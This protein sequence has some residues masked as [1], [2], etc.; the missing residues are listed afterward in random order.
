M[1]TKTAAAPFHPIV[2]LE[3]A[4]AIASIAAHIHN[5]RLMWLKSV[6]QNAPLPKKLDPETVTKDWA[7]GSHISLGLW[8]WGTR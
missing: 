5:I 1:A 2:A 3:T 7:I 6:D 4:S 8:E